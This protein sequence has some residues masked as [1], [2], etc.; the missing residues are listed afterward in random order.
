MLSRM[1]A[2]AVSPAGQRAALSI[3]IFHRVFP[4]TDP[5]FP[6]VPD[7]NCF[8]EILAWLKR[9]FNVLPLAHAVKALKAGRLPA[10]AAAITFDD[11]Y[12]DNYS[13]ALP[14]L[15]QHALNATFFVSTGF[16]DGGRMWND[17]V[18]ESV[19][20]AAAESIDLSSLGLGA[21]LLRS[22]LEKR[23]AID[24][25]LPRLKYLPLAE[26]LSRVNEVASICAASLP[27]KLMMSSDQVGRLHAAGM[28]VG[29]HTV[30]HP[31]LAS[32]D[33]AVAKKEICDGKC[34]LEEI[35]KAPVTL[36]A[37]PNGQPGR[38]YTAE[39]VGIVRD[40]GFAAAVSTAIGV[41]RMNADYLQLPRFTPWDRSG[42]RFSLRLVDNMRR[43]VHLA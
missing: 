34:R 22:P 18:I 8:A 12:E 40:A 9:S 28:Q 29:A 36:F 26:R 21:F 10:R 19:R 13:V 37:Y 2:S 42:T 7:A 17:T 33:S 32:I 20:R 27:N 24:S 30:N 6:E 35:V 41:S 25:I 5:L 1:L 43:K 3:L 16:L 15:Q 31:I 14:L 11:G 23:Q 39:H 4:A 38:D